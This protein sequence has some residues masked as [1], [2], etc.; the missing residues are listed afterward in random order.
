MTV[1]AHPLLD[2][3]IRKCKLKNDSA[4]AGALGVDPGCVSHVRNKTYG[5]SDIMFIRLHELTG[6][7]I[8]ELRELAGLP[9]KIL[10]RKFDRT[11][12]SP[13]II[14]KVSGLTRYCMGMDGKLHAGA[15][16][17]N[18]YIKVSDVLEVLQS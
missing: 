8:A 10:G 4:L 3:A 9:P 1:A 6:E 14:D 5:V 7:P 15:V 11:P 12:V 18:S 2:H 16:S 13:E 17:T